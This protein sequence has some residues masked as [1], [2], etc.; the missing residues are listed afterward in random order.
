M[1]RS[2]PRCGS[3]PRREAP[4]WRDGFASGAVYH[5]GDEHVAFLNEV[6]ALN[7]QANPLHPEL[8]PSAV[9]YEAEVVAMTAS[10]LGGGA[11]GVDT[12]CGTVSSGGTESIL[13][14]MKTYRDQARDERG[15]TDPEMVVPLSAHAAFDK[16]AQYF[17]IRTVP[18]PLGVGLA[19]RRGRGATA[20]HRQDRGGGGIGS[21]VPPRRDRP[22]RRVVRVGALPGHR[23]S[24]RLLSGRLRAAVR[25]EARLPRRAV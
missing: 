1:A 20:H 15:I 18:V 14:A 10:M 21:R 11:G 5:G 13:L 6:Y 17:G 8:W 3:W 23:V 9:K 25:R 12:V 19:R 4:K 7:S 2:W 16:A 22:D 24:H